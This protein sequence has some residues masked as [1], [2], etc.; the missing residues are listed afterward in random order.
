MF[1]TM[2]STKQLPLSA[3]EMVRLDTVAVR[4][5]VGLVDRVTAADLARP[6]PCEAWTLYGLLAHMA[7]QHHGFAAASAGEDGLEAWKLRRLGADPVAAYREAAG[8]VLAAFAADGVIDRTFAL[9]EITSQQRFPAAQAISFHFIDY[10]VHSWD[11]AR[12]LG[13]PVSFEPPVLAAAL[14]VARAVPDGQRRLAPGAAF[15]PA[16]ARPAA[17]PLAQIVAL[18]GRSPSWPG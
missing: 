1:M 16:I 5:S 8:E 7:T 14:A 2:S 10:V 18:L 3:A 4:T 15:A 11:V 17:D 12:T 9:P 13:L 6:T